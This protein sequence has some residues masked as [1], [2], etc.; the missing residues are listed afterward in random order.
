MKKIFTIEA[1][2]LILGIL[3]LSSINSPA[4]LTNIFTGTQK[5]VENINDEISDFS[6]YISTPDGIIKNTKNIPANEAQQISAMTK[7][8]Y[9]AFEILRNPELTTEQ[10]NDANKTVDT[11]IKKLREH[12]LIPETMSNNQ[13]RE[14]ISGEFGKKVYEKLI[15]KSRLNNIPTNFEQNGEWIHNTLCSVFWT[16]GDEYQSMHFLSTIPFDVLITIIDL[17]IKVGLEDIA[18]NL[19]NSPLFFIFLI[20]VVSPK[21]IIPYAYGDLVPWG[22]DNSGSI[23]TSGL[24]GNWDLSTDESNNRVRV[25]MIGGI[26]LWFI[27]TAMGIVSQD[28]TGFAFYIRAKKCSGNNNLQPLNIN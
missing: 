9:K 5:N 12:E 26:G 27:N 18:L 11:A 24:L 15:K 20:P 1:T 14:V 10:K 21:Y 25:N 8:A 23:E 22:Y 6:C 2:V 17:L 13:V 7:E 28:F 4:I 19:L 3:L 16:G